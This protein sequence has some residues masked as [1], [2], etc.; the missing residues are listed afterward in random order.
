MIGGFQER[1]DAVRRL[2]RDAETAAVLV[3]SAEPLTVEETAAFYRELDRAGLFVGAVVMNRTV[4][5][6]LLAR[7]RHRLSPM[8]RELRRK[9]REAR[10]ELEALGDR[11]RRM[12][13]NLRAVAE[14]VPITLVPAFPRDVASLA[15]LREIAEIFVPDVGRPGKVT[16]IR[17]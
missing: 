6:T 15:S 13:A 1:A 5:E 17:A 2:L 16:S 4:P 10:R 11:D 12:A 9:L 3:T 8:P 14:G 7:V